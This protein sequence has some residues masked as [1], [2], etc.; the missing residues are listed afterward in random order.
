VT[1]R[2]LPGMPNDRLGVIG[3]RQLVTVQ[4]LSIARLTAHPVAI[5]PQTFIAVTGRGPSDS[6][7]SG[8]TSFLAAVSLLLGDPE[9]RVSG[10]GA[11]SVEALLFE[12]VTAGA[13]VGVHAATEGYVIGVF[14]EPDEVE[15][16]THTVWMRI[17]AGRPY[18][19]VRHAPG[20]HLATGST[21]RERHDAAPPLFRSL[22]GDPLGSTEYA[23]VLYGRSPRV[24]A[25]VAS[26][27]RVRSRPSL[28]KLD[29]GT[30]SPEEIGDALV[31]LTGRATLFDRDQQDRRDLAAK[32]AELATQIKFDAEQVKH[33]D[34]ILDQ[35]AVRQRLRELAQETLRLRRAQL[36]RSVLDAYAKSES[37]SMLLA[38]AE[39]IRDEIAKA[40]GDAEEE[41]EALRDTAALR[42]TLQETTTR[43]GASSHA[44]EE[45][46]RWEGALCNGLAQIETN[47]D[48]N[49]RAA[50]GHHVD[51]DGDAA[52]WAGTRDRFAA[53][54]LTARGL[55]DDAV[56]LVACLETDLAR[57]RDGQFG[58]AGLLMRVLADHEIPSTSLASAT[59]LA[60]EG[61][62]AWEARLAPWRHAVCVA[63][64]HLTNALQ[65]LADSPGAL[66]VSRPGPA[67]QGEAG[68]PAQRGSRLP[69][70]ILDAPAEA[71]TLLWSLAEQEFVTVPV[72]HTTDE[73]TGV[74][75]IGGFDVPVIGQEELLEHLE[76]R[77]REARERHG[78][79]GSRVGS[80][81]KD[82][83]RAGTTAAR[84]EAA[85]AV[86][87]LIGKLAKHRVLLTEHLEKLP[88][89]K[90]ERDQAWRAKEKAARAVDERDRNYNKLSDLVRDT[91]TRLRTQEA[92]TTRLKQ[93]TVPDDAV[94]SAW[95][96][97]REAALRELGWAPEHSGTSGTV[98]VDRLQEEATAP[99]LTTGA[100][101]VERRRASV[102]L[103]AARNH[104]MEA[105]A[106]V[107]QHARGQGSPPP[108]T[109]LDTDRYQQAYRH[110][111]EDRGG[112][113]FESALDGLRLWL[114]EEA[115]RD[116]AA[117][118]QARE[119]RA[120]RASKTDYVDTQ[121]RQL[122]QALQETQGAITQ[123]ASSALAS[124]SSMLDQLNRKANSYGADLQ[125]EIIPPAAP[126]Q[127]WTCRVTPRWRR[128]PN[129]PM[130]PYDNVT[131]TAQEK[132]F[133]IHLVLAALLAAPDSRGRV[134]ILDELADSLGSEHRREV[135]DAIATAAQQYGITILATCQD[136][137][138]IEAK[139]YCREILYFHYPSKSMPLNR[140][141]RMFGL[142]RNGA[143]VELTAEAL[144]EGRGLT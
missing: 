47:L 25:Y 14:A 69:D 115:E 40:L 26:R 2:H 44:H 45:A 88:R 71:E 128:N 102:L 77:L 139:S 27:G 7:E 12:P 31:A 18:V 1:E 113:M 32:Q 83:D 59:R 21:D 53:E 78:T 37:A 121:T 89:L 84:A 19:Q 8:K 144:R 73:R 103:D 41:R 48:R 49:R 119:A 13:P 125:H 81:E 100:T 23:R 131:N 11:S 76:N 95:G 123:R 57:A 141:T 30:F 122:Q 87:L 5:L 63:T 82:L 66:I 16:T 50:A 118:E 132:L 3:P 79:L 133:S 124:I 43:L 99:P 62:A 101:G 120:N 9:W 6:N 137:I 29:A 70:G 80:L 109:A 108:A 34:G 107:R 117:P 54:L 136:T 35:V 96:R 75:V 22:G 38:K 104:L 106:A 61:R 91:K 20:L 114:N 51:R 92:E 67:E 85:E 42:V 97:G 24:L 142:D 55:H 72:P 17:A 65:T 60:S 64:T 127:D 36:A 105:L 112:A 39:S 4:T 140:P 28:L 52:S 90:D 15:A 10:N 111:E 68:E 126:D 129:G 116:A 86:L 93:A 138:I 143:R 134:L 135:L 94:L 46:V 130:L 58:A 98:D 110:G 56:Q 33:E 74:R